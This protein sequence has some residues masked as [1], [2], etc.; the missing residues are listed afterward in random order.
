MLM[1]I[2]VLF[3]IRSALDS[4][5]KEAGLSGWWQLNAPAT[6]EK[7]QQHAAVRQEHFIF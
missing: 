3:A 1:S 4:A 6:V 2:S 5:R 7:I